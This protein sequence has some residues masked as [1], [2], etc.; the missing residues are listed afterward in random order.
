[1]P[2]RKL[3]VPGAAAPVTAEPSV[4]TSHTSYSVSKVP[5]FLNHQRVHSLHERGLDVINSLTGW[6][7]TELV[8]YLR[9]V[10]RCWQPADLL[11][12]PA[13]P[14]FFDQVRLGRGVL[15]PWFTP[16]ACCALSHASSH[17][18]PQVSAL[19]AASQSLPQE[20]LVVLVGDMVTEEALPSYMNMLNTLDGTK[21][22][23]EAQKRGVVQGR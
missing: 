11:P 15:A 6:A 7:G 4:T 1:L 14:D 2:P 3:I 19:R 21:V 9:P 13:S 16:A 10:Q 17:P 8:R 12:D 18:L 22:S 20:Y 5:V 23:M